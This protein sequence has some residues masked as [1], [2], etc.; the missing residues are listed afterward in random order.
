M[1]FNTLLETLKSPGEDTD[2]DSVYTDIGNAYTSVADELSSARAAVE[3]LTDEKTALESELLKLKAT[4]FDLLQR[5]S[6]D[7]ESRDDVDTSDEG[8]DIEI[9]F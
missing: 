4:N 9:V 3:L 2:I 6:V 8:E 7:V 5:V 1:D